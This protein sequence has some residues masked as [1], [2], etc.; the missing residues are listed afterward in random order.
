MC[1]PVRYYIGAALL[2]FV[3]ATAQADVVT[4]TFEG[5][6]DFGPAGSFYNGP[7]GGEYGITFPEDARG[8]VDIDA[9]GCCSFGNEPSPSTG[10]FWNSFNQGDSPYVAYANVQGGFTNRVEFF[11][12]QPQDSPP[13]SFGS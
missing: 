5:V 6:G 1:S 8:V 3:H 12:T 13:S 11:Y 7:R 9:G 4:L 10:L 2:V